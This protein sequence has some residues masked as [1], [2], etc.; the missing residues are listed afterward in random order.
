MS[1]VKIEEEKVTKLHVCSNSS[2]ISVFVPYLSE[3]SRKNFQELGT[4][5]DLHSKVLLLPKRGFYDNK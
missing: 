4:T 1:P 5:D 2:V 3:M